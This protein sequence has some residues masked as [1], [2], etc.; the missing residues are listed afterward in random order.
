VQDDDMLCVSVI[1]AGKARAALPIPEKHSS[2]SATT[3][4]AAAA[5][6]AGAADSAVT[7]S[8]NSDNNTSSGSANASAAA[9]DAKQAGELYTY[10]S[11]IWS[12]H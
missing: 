6:A 11:S 9:G 2:T 10:I 7:S 1:G 5:A 3:T 12:L 4:T 8:T